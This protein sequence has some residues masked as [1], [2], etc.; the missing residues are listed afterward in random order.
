MKDHYLAY[1]LVARVH[2]NTKKLPFNTMTLLDNR[3]VERFIKTYARIQYCA[4]CETTGIRA[5]GYKTF[6][7][8]WKALVPHVTVMRPMTDLCSVCQH[9]STALM[10]AA[11]TPEEDKSEV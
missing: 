11:N 3:N 10:R 8:L 6:C 1:G 7:I 2:G 5:A 4:A 9:N